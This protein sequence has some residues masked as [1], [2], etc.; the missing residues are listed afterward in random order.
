MQ[1]RSRHFLSW[2][3][4][5][6]FLLAAVAFFAMNLPAAADENSLT[7]PPDPRCAAGALLWQQTVDVTDLDPNGVPNV[8]VRFTRFG[9]TSFAIP[10]PLPAAFG[11]GLSVTIAEAVAWDGYLDRKNSADQPNERFKIVFLKAGAFVAETGWTGISETDDGVATGWMSDEW[12]GSLGGP[13]NLPNGADQILL[14]HWSDVTYGTG[15]KSSPNSVVPTSVCIGYI[16]HPT[17]TPPPP[18]PTNTPVPPT[19]TPPPPTPTNTPVP[20]TPTP[21]PPTPTNT[22]VPPTPTPPPPTPTNTPVPPTPTPPPPTP[23]NTPVP[24]TPTP[25]ADVG[26]GTPGYWMNHPE[27]WPVDTITIGGVVY[28]KDMAI[29]IMKDPV[30]RDKTF[31]LFPALVAAKLNVMM[32][33]NASCISG[34][35]AAADTWMAA[36]PVGSGVSGSSNAWK[37]GEPLYLTLDLYNNGRLCAPSRD[38]LE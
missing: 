19:P 37:T 22:P 35:I 9:T 20:P 10:G 34:T 15:D 11:S 23:T 29:A 1:Q 6:G 30:K 2:L 28:T 27:A 36:N 7:P 24:P 5:A 13:I 26:T 14:V 16:P 12:V 32:G 31:T 33:T 18:T 8:A 3:S 25:R 38:S 17:P 21:P 4:A